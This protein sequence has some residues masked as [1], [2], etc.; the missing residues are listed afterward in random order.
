MQLDRVRRDAGLSVLEIEERDPDDA[1]VR[2]E[3]QLLAC[4]AH[5]PA[6]ILVA[7]RAH[8]DEGDSASRRST[9]CQSI[10][11]PL[12]ALPVSGPHRLGHRALAPVGGGS[13]TALLMRAEI[14]HTRRRDP[15]KA[16]TPRPRPSALS[17]R[18]LIPPEVQ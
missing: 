1:R 2:A 13:T 4:L 10:V 5:L 8:A 3:P 6:T 15:W 7:P 14:V 17:G 9:C 18:G 11:F 16:S 12:P